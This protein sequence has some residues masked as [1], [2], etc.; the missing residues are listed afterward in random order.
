MAVDKE[1]VNSKICPSCVKN[2]VIKEKSTKSLNSSVLLRS[3]T[4]KQ[5]FPILT[6]VSMQTAAFR[7]VAPCSLEEVFRRVIVAYS[8]RRQVH[9]LSP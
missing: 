9:H 7:V 6:A 8:L 2:Y 5:R 3:K 1:Y 4:N